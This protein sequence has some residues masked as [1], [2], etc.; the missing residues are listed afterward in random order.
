MQV[1]RCS[2]LMAYI[3]VGSRAIIPCPPPARTARTGAAPPRNHS[4]RK[5]TFLPGRAGGYPPGP[6]TDPD[7]RNSRI[8]F[9]RQSLCCPGK[10]PLALQSTGY[11]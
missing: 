8:R 11:L 9:L 4:L 6:P 1:D 3:P 2:D 7:V 10:V 5:T